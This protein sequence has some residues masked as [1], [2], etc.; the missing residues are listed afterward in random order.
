MLIYADIK[1]KKKIN[2]N[3]NLKIFSFNLIINILIFLNKIYRFINEFLKYYQKLDDAISYLFSSVN[4]KKLLKDLK[5]E[6][7]FMWILEQTLEIKLEFIKKNFK[8]RQ[9]FCFEQLKV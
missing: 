4:E 5:K 8:T 3:S 6:K 1:I 2:I 7:L 9:V